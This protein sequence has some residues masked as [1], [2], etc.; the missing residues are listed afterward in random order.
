MNRSAETVPFAERTGECVWRENEMGN[1]QTSDESFVLTAHTLRQKQTRQKAWSNGGGF[2]GYCMDLACRRAQMRLTVSE[3]LHAMLSD[4]QEPD[5]RFQKD[6][7]EAWAA[8]IDACR[9]G[10]NHA[11]RSKQRKAVEALSAAMSRAELY[12]DGFLRSYTGT[13]GEGGYAVVVNPYPIRRRMFTCIRSTGP[14]YVFDGEE[15]LPAQYIGGDG[16]TAVEVEMDGFSIRTLRVED[17]APDC[18]IETVPDAGYLFEN[19]KMKVTVLPDGRIASLC[20]MEK[21]EVLSEMGGNVLEARL[22]RADGTTEHL[23]GRM[24]RLARVEKGRLFDN[25]LIDGTL[26]DSRYSMIMYLPH[27]T[28]QRIEIMTDIVASDALHEALEQPGSEIVTRWHSNMNTPRVLTDIPFRCDRVSEGEEILSSNGIAVTEGGK[29]FLYDHQGVTRSLFEGGTLVNCWARGGLGAKEDLPAGMLDATGDGDLASRSYRY[30]NAIDLTDTDDVGSMF[31][32]IL[33]YQIPM[34][35]LRTEK[36]VADRTLFSVE[37]DEMMFSS[38]VREK[39]RVLIKMW[40]ATDRRVPLRWHGAW[41]ISAVVG[42]DGRRMTSNPYAKPNEIVL[43][44]A[45]KD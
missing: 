16:A 28:S 17:N 9:P 32:R 34:I 35:P 31:S 20:S 13:K 8:L 23:C 45:E 37:G 24:N 29:G 3:T 5:P 25:V 44:V 15:E 27:G 10:I 22:T 41:R 4:V 33:Y 21:G 14:L 43:F 18:V 1:G 12:S 26:G 2:F 38:A 11:D 36:A 40:N 39:G 30:F 7:G 42:E 6:N 19:E